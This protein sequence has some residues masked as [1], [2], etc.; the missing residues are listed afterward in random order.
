MG[1]RG[2]GDTVSIG[3]CS[4][5]DASPMG[6]VGSL[7]ASHRGSRALRTQAVW[8]CRAPWTHPLLGRAA[9]STAVPD[10]CLRQERHRVFFTLRTSPSW[11]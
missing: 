3:L 8:G 2:S 11:E 6:V 5:A 1:V 9:G 10:F 7:N 4:F